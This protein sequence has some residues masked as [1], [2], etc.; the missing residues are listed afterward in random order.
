MQRPRPDYG[1][2]DRNT[3]APWRA[4]AAFGALWFIIEDG[5]RRRQAGA[6]DLTY[7]PF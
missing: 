2:I 5:A 7:L 4:A 1:L 6:K 3:E